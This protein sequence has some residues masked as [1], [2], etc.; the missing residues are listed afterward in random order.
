MASPLSRK[1]PFV[2]GTT[3]LGVMFRRKVV[4]KLLASTL[5]LFLLGIGSTT[6]A[7]S[8]DEDIISNFFGFGSVENA[9]KEL[10]DTLGAQVRQSN[11][12]TVISIEAERVKWEFP[13]KSQPYYPSIIKSQVLFTDGQLDYQV[14]ILCGA[15]KSKCDEMSK[16]YAAHVKAV[17]QR[18]SK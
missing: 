3:E 11:D 7:E 17:K 15:E 1:R 2:L 12:R 16:S 13:S 14:D 18:F 5:V 10:S 9:I 4:R 6:F 8:S